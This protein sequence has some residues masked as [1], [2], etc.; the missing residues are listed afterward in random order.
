MKKLSRFCRFLI[1][2]SCILMVL[3]VFG[4]V[5]VAEFAEDLEGTLQENIALKVAAE[6]EKEVEEG[7]ESY[8]SMDLVEESVIQDLTVEVSR[9]YAL[10]TSGDLSFSE[11]EGYFAEDSSI[12]EVLRTY[13]SRRYDDHD[14]V[15][16]ENI[17][18]GEI[19]VVG[20][21]LVES[22]VTFEYIVTV[23]EVEKRYFA[24]YTLEIQR[25]GTKVSGL[26][27]N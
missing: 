19:I 16:F 17:Q 27:M 11:I 2:L 22:T 8:P 9:K 23:G 24:D 20:E 26:R 12:L 13:S 7:L 5:K 18:V 3:C 21:N 10:F 6:R 1:G 15:D 14:G 25:D 4:W